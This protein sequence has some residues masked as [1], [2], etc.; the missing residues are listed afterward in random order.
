MP[1]LKGEKSDSIKKTLLL[2]VPITML[3]W[4]FMIY[5]YST[6]SAQ[7]INLPKYVAYFNGYYT[8]PSYI[9]SQ[10]NITINRSFTISFW[11]Y[12]TRVGNGIPGSSYSEDMIDVNNNTGE[13]SQIYLE[14]RGNGYFNLNICEMN[15]SYP[16]NCSEEFS[17]ENWANQWVHI[18]ET[19]N[20]GT[21]L[22][23][24]NGRPIFYSKG[25]AS[26]SGVAWGPAVSNLV[27][28]NAKV[29]ISYYIPYSVYAYD[30]EFAGYMS[31]VQIYGDA[32]N[33]SEVSV[34]YRSGIAGYPLSSEDLLGWW[35][36]DGNANS[37]VPKTYTGVIFGN[38]SFVTP[39]R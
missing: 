6:Y 37:F 13:L 1:R 36:L 12:P 35:P 16:A 2:A 5:S 20:N 15:G 17:M 27:I 9:L 23:Y 18:A 10:T 19:Y 30:S 31:N 22:V 32:L 38:V 33:S 24:A 39:P 11:M 8:P 34:L 14:W 29:Y 26:G 3:I 21:I 28:S 4:L 7:Q 25:A